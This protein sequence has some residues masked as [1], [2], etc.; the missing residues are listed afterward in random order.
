MTY[1]RNL[2]LA[3]AIEIEFIVPNNTLPNGKRISRRLMRPL[4]DA[5]NIS[6]V[7]VTYDYTRSENN[8]K[9]YNELVVIADLA[10]N[11]SVRGCMVIKPYGYAIWEKIQQELDKI[12]CNGSSCG[13]KIIAVVKGNHHIKSIT[14][15]DSLKTVIYLD[16]HFPIPN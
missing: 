7:Y 1:N 12:E 6:E 16:C 5:I 3:T 15:D 13:G 10:E 4:I 11:S 14:I 2:N 9:W 8:S